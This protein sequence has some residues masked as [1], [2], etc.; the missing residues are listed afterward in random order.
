MRAAC[1]ETR[2]ARP[3]Q[4]RLLA[5]FRAHKADL[6][7][8]RTQDPYALWVSEIMLQQTQVATVIPYY[9]RFLKAFPTVKALAAASDHRLLKLWQGLGYYRRAM[10]LRAAAREV[11]A[12]HGGRVPDDPQTFASLPGIGRYTCAAVQSIAFG[13]RLAILDGNAIRVFARWFA[14]TKDVTRGAVQRE[15]WHTAELLMPGNRPG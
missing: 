15:L 6:P 10:N 13:R 5:W 12:K 1:Q 4:E 14:I 3:L 7:W 2:R 11:V 8:R 9:T